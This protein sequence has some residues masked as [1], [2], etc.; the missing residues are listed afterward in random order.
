MPMEARQSTPTRGTGTGETREAGL[1]VVLLSTV[2]PSAALPLHGLFVQRRLDSVPGL[3]GARV[4]APTPWFPLASSPRRGFRPRLPRREVVAGRAVEHPRFLSV[5][6]FAKAMDGPSLFLRLLPLLRRLHRSEPIDVLDVH[7]VYPEGFAAVLLGR[8]LNVPVVLTLRGVLGQLGGFRVRRAEAA[9]ALRRAERVVALS[10]SLRAMAAALGRPARSIAVI[11]NAVDGDVFTLL[12]RADARRRLGLAGP[13]PRLLFVGT[14]SPRKGIERVLDA[15]PALAER[16]P[17][18]ELLVVGGPGAE[19]SSPQ[20]LRRYAARLGVADRLVL[21]G[22]HPPGELAPWYSAADA[23]VLPSRLE[24]SPNAVLEALACGTPVVATPVGEIP[25]VLADSG[26]GVLAP[27]EGDGN[28][29]PAIAAALDRDW[30]RAALRWWALRRR[31]ADV[32]E[33][34]R[35]QLRGAV[36]DHAARRGRADAAA[37]APEAAR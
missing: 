13:G 12:E 20:G 33:A 28:L 18:I 21:A 5:P 31:W 1:R 8:A 25:E 26:G 3:A 32:G 37:V 15:L 16:W 27:R 29:A 34:V 36:R 14:P 11:P 23:F 17:A 30:D 24:G 35:E 4:V 7:F 22:P 2:Y 9:F 19:R 10:D 6:R